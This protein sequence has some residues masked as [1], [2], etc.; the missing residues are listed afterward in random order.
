VEKRKTI[1]ER[2]LEDA[3]RDGYALFPEGWRQK[4]KAA[5]L[6]L[7]ECVMAGR[8]CVVVERWPDRLAAPDE[9]VKDP[10]NLVVKYR[11]LGRIEA[12]FLERI[13][14]TVRGVERCA[15][16]VITFMGD[17]YQTFMA[18]S[19]HIMRHHKVD[20]PRIHVGGCPQEVTH[21]VV[22]LLID[23]VLD[24]ARTGG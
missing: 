19:I 23:L 21:E 17:P 15:G 9:V 24:L 7:Q 14:L 5:E 16:V 3:S 10:D 20:P 8:P 13:D 12:G 1:L 11:H 4:K 2:R 18:D 6:W 22:M